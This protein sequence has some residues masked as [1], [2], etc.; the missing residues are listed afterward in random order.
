MNQPQIVNYKDIDPSCSMQMPDGRYLPARP[1]GYQ[2]AGLRNLRNRLKLAWNVFT[3]KYDAF[4][5]E[6][7]ETLQ[8]MV[9]RFH[10]P[11][12]RTRTAEEIKAAIENR[13][14]RNL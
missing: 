10:P 2:Y 6:P 4:D 14:E 5:W 11:K 7:T 8:E 9:E 1:M 13:P 12:G 3:G